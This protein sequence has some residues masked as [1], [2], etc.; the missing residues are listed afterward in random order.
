MV[1]ADVCL[2]AAGDIVKL[3][4]SDTGAAVQV[5]SER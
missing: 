1:L 4:R 2:I 3:E 5:L